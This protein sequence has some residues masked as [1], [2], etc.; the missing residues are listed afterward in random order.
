MADVFVAKLRENKK[1]I[2]MKLFLQDELKT[3][4][5]KNLRGCPR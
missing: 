5:D 3:Q 1:E 2:N 4:I